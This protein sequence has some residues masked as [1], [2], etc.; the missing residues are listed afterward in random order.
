ML[1][2]IFG[3]NDGTCVNDIQKYFGYLPRPIDVEIN[4]RKVSFLYISRG[5]YPP[6][7]KALFPNFPFPLPSPFPPPQIPLL[8]RSQ[9]GAGE[10]CKPQPT[11][12]FVCLRA[13][14]SIWQQLLYVFLYTE[15]C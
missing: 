1:W 7:T 11:S 2:K 6:T 15:I 3:V 9:L 4:V 10:R 12:I 5:V 14:N 13:K 8:P